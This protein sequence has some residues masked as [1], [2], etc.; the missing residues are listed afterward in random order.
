MFLAFLLVGWL[1]TL[2]EARITQNYLLLML[3]KHQFET[4]GF[5]SALLSFA[6][7]MLAYGVAFFVVWASALLGAYAPNVGK[8]LDG[9]IGFERISIVAFYWAV[10]AGLI[11]YLLKVVRL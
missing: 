1:I 4:G 2:P 7:Y 6:G 9:L 5:A 3:L 10:S 11:Y 8:K